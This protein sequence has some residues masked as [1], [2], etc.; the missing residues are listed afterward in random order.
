MKKIVI[1]QKNLENI[2]LIDND[3][4]DLITYTKEISKIMELSKVC[5]LETTSGNIIL[6]PSEISSI[7]VLEFEFEKE[8]P[9]KIITPPKM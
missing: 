1:H 4:R 9:I 2:I 3:S 6:K 5:I 7:T 8:E